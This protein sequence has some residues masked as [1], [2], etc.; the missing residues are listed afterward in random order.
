M[1]A[2]TGTR[3][4]RPERPL[5]KMMKMRS[6]ARCLFQWVVSAA[7]VAF[8]SVAHAQLESVVYRFDT[9]PLVDPAIYLT[10]NRPVVS[11]TAGRLVAFHGK[12]RSQTLGGVDGVFVVD[13]VAADTLEALEGDIAGTANPFCDFY[14]P[15]IKAGGDVAWSARPV[16]ASRDVFRTG[17]TP[18]SLLGGLSPLARGTRSHFDLP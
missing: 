13:P 9:A 10:L 17:R 14:R 8:A 1:G 7:L 15:W 16:G 18:G 12:V 3:W 4:R 2:A 6:Q 11:D 5:G